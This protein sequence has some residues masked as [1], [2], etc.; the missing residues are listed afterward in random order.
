VER[1]QHEP[2]LANLRFSLQMVA[3][4]FGVPFVEAVNG[5]GW[6][7]LGRTLLVASRLRRPDCAADLEVRGPEMAS[8]TAAVAWYEETTAALVRRVARP[9]PSP[10]AATRKAEATGTGPDPLVRRPP[11]AARHRGAEVAQA[12]AR[13]GIRQ[14]GAVASRGRPSAAAREAIPTAP[15]WQVG[16]TGGGSHDSRLQ[17]VEFAYQGIATARRTLNQVE[18][19]QRGGTVGFQEKDFRA[20]S[21]LVV[22]AA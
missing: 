21:Q 22:G 19:L 3:L 5:A 20:K 10:V 17:F 1:P 2:P 9:A 8:L 15:D 14:G 12:A 16:L 4:A 7:A 13:A 6:T 11:P 18:P